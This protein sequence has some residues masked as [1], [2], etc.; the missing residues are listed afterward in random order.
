MKFLKSFFKNLAI[1]VGVLVVLALINRRYLGGFNKVEVKEQMM[2]PYTIAYTEFVGDYS[3]V[4]PSMDK[5]YLALSGA[6]ILSATGVGIYY[7]DPTV[8]SWENLR[9]DVGAIVV[10]NEI[11]KV[12]Q[13]AELKIKNIGG[14][15]S[16]VAEFPIKNSVSYMAGVIK[17][18]PALKK[19]M[20][21]KGYSSEVPVMELYDM[22]AKKIY[23]VIEITK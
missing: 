7:D 12:P 23:Y 22:V 1:L 9:S 20:I 2:G 3:K 6:G 16:M 8:I 4:W 19:Y 13:S 18:Y 14:K 21:A 15:M 5:V 10:G 11:T 17:V